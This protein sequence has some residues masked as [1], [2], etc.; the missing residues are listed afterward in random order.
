MRFDFLGVDFLAASIDQIFNSSFDDQISRQI[1]PHEVTGSIV[2]I[3]AECFAVPLRRA[4][5]AANGVGAATPK[6]ANLTGRDLDSVT[7]DNPDFVV[8]R[9]H[10]TLCCER[11][12]LR[13]VETRV[14]EQSLSHTEDLLHHEVR[15]RAF[16]TACR[17]F[18]EPL[19]AD[20]DHL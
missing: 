5:V 20:S 14:A 15:E 13:I 10:A 1:E 4:V 9:K 6:L 7:I 11:Y 17:M 18:L 2:S 12:V 19:T 8:W 3:G 16:Q